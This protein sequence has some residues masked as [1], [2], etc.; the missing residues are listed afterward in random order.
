[1]GPTE[2]TTGTSTVSWVTCLALDTG[3][4]RLSLSL[5]VLGS[6]E[7]TR[8]GCRSSLV[9]VHETHEVGVLVFWPLFSEGDL[10]AR[11]VPQL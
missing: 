8:E 2:S 4:D 3:C 11:G 1:M 9:Y 6:R 5:L 7:V 10:E